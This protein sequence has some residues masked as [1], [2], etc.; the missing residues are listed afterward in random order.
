MFD[1]YNI[2]TESDQREAFI[3][4]DRL[5]VEPPHRAQG[6]GNEL[7]TGSALGLSELA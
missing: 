5:R 2:V 1:R 4:L 3:R 7:F 6:C